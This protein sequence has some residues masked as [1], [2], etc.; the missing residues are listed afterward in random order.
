MIVAVAAVSLGLVKGPDWGWGTVKVTACW[1]VTAAAVAAFALV[2]RRAKTPVVNLSLFRSRLFAVTNA[3]MVLS[4]A[5]IAMQLLGLSLYLQQAWHWS[6]L[7]AGAAIAPGPA[8]VLVASQAAGLLPARLRPRPGVL[9]VTGFAVQA[10]GQALLVVSMHTWHSYPGAILP[11]WITIGI[12]LGWAMPNI[13]A[14]AT[15][16]LPKTESAAG[17]A[18][19][20]MGRQLGSVLGNAALVAIL[21]T[22]VAT[23]AQG[24][25]LNAGWVTVALYAG[26]AL[27]ALPLLSQR[28]PAQP[29]VP[30]P[31]PKLAQTEPT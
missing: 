19:V 23:G 5:A 22:A 12:G 6:P 28:Q 20:Q 25:Y 11:G 2:N 3:A 9:A 15:G 14:L 30:A 27:I 16:D 17:S 13:T 26:R 24:P 4:S 29:S 31:A 21:G 10:A 18:V 7:A 8:F 1:I